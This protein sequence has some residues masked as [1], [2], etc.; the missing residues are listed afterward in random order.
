MNHVF[1]AHMHLLMTE[2]GCLGLHGRGRSYKAERSGQKLNN[3]HCRKGSAQMLV[4]FDRQLH[5]Q[6][7]KF[8]LMNR[9]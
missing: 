4:D 1:S 5:V 6:Q 3:E 2:T 7:C 8:H 9:Q